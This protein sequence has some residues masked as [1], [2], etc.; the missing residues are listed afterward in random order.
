MKRHQPIVAWYWSP[1]E[2]IGGY[3]LKRLEMPPY[4][5]EKFKCLTDPNC[6]NS[7]VTGWKPGEVVLAVATE[8]RAKA[9]TA[10]AFLSK[11]I[12]RNDV[13]IEFLAL[14]DENSASLEEVARYSLRKHPEVWTSWVP[15]DVAERVQAALSRAAGS[16]VRT[17]SPRTVDP[18]TDRDANEPRR[19][20]PYPRNT[21]RT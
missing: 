3:R 8:L 1:T 16:P 13:V 19:R 6:P 11:F 14:G 15:A 21:S 2:V 4:D 5:P 20:A 7:Q 12:V 10:A 18:E 9:P 17:R